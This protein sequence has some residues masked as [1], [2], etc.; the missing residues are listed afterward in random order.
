MND[1]KKVITIL[2]IDFNRAK[3]L[4]GLDQVL[5]ATVNKMM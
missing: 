4:I 5:F 3:F 2:P 1:I